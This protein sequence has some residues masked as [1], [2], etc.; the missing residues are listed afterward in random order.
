MLLHATAG[1]TGWKLTKSSLKIRKVAS[2]T[3][4]WHRSWVNFSEDGTDFSGFRRRPKFDASQLFPIIFFRHD[5]HFRFSLFSTLESTLNATFSLFGIENR[6]WVDF[7]EDGTD[8]TG[9][10]RRVGRNLTLGKKLFFSDKSDK[11]FKI[12]TLD[13]YFFRLWEVF[14]TQ[15]FQRLATFVTILIF[16]TTFVVFTFNFLQKLKSKQSFLEIITESTRDS[17]LSSQYHAVTNKNKTQK[18]IHLFKKHETIFRRMEMVSKTSKFSQYYSRK[19]SNWN[20]AN[21]GI[22]ELSVGQLLQGASWNFMS[23]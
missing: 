10:R 9:F 2:L 13:F 6:N 11:S 14:W 8:F 20:C 7:S 17:G 1:L 15:L 22:F 12:F 18:K 16:K 5:F 21:L 19:L 3:Q 4:F 23:L